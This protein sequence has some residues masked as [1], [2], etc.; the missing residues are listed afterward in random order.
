MMGPVRAFVV[1]AGG[2]LSHVVPVPFFAEPIPIEW[3]EQN[4]IAR[5][6]LRFT[7]ASRRVYPGFVQLLAFMS[8]NVEKHLKAQRDLFASAVKGDEETARATRAFY[9]EY[10]A[11][12]DLPAEFYLQTVRSVFQDYALARGELTWRGRPVQPA[13]IARTAL[14]TV[15]GERTT[16]AASARPSPRTSCAA[17]CLGIGNATICRPASATTASSAGCAGAP[18]SIPCSRTSYSPATDRDAAH[19]TPLGTASKRRS[20]MLI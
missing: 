18:R 1:V 17:V 3:F 16:S 14:L 12:L 8:M 15:E 19:R 9:D 10:F 7:G 20:A 11:V 13:A 5:V 6:P 2:M 4:L